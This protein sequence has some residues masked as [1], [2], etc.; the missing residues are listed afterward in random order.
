MSTVASEPSRPGPASDAGRGSAGALVRSPTAPQQQ[1]DVSPPRRRQRWRWVVAGAS[2][3]AVAGGGW[4]IGRQVRS[5]DQAASQAAPPMPSWITAAVERRVLAQTVIS[6]GDVRPQVS[7]MVGVPSSIE[8]SPVVTA[9]GVAVGDPV[10]EGARVME[11]SGRPVFVLQGDVPVYRSLKPGMFGAD[12]SQLQAA[13]SRLGCDTDTDSGVYGVATKKCVASLYSDAGYQ[14]VPTSPTETADLATAGQAVIDAQGA[15]D[16]AQSTL[17]KAMRGP[18]DQDVL[19]AGIALKAAQRALN[20]TVASSNAAV[21]LADGNVTRAQTKLDRVKADPNVAPGDLDAAQADL[22]AT[23]AAAGDARR[24]RTSTVAGARDAVTLAQSAVDAL[25]KDPDVTVESKALAG[26]LA[27][28]VRAQQALDDLQ[29]STGAIVPKG[30]VVFAPSLPARVQQAVTSL[31]PLGASPQP[32]GLDGSSAG[33]GNQLATLAAGDLVV[34]MTLPVSERGLV[35]VG[36]A[37]ELLDEQSN[38]TYPAKIVAIAD[39]P[40][41]GSD[42]QL[43]LPIVI[44]PDTPLPDDLSGINLRVTVTAASTETATLVVP[45]AAVSS[46][47]DGSTNV[48]ILPNGGGTKADPVIVP[49]VAGISA[50]GFV[51]IKPVTAGALVEGDRVVVGR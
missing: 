31:G 37:V 43:G 12:V 35:R 18:S 16:A 19:A 39:T 22:D 23:N 36:M 41:T 40:A 7:I 47:A 27:A 48:S 21:A 49:V 32:G 29:A 26:A 38:I 10:K 14:P 45:V 24:N 8:G 6:R 1:E 17:D 33:D 9:I 3:V 5:A 11:V 2:L 50:D 30:E 51:S 34:S 13:L 46:A 4:V 25:N 28:R 15:A 42:G 44:T 20:D